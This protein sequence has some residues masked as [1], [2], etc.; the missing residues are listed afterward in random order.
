LILTVQILKGF[1]FQNI[2]SSNFLYQF[3]DT[4]KILEVT[5]HIY[6]IGFSFQIIGAINILV[7]LLISSLSSNVAKTWNLYVIFCSAV[8][9]FFT[10][11]IFILIVT[12]VVFV[13]KVVYHG[14]LDDKLKDVLF[15]EIGFKSTSLH[16]SLCSI[17]F[18]LIVDGLSF[19]ALSF[20]SST[21][22]HTKVDSSKFNITTN[23]LDVSPCVS[24][25]EFSN[26]RMSTL[27]AVPP[28]PPPPR[29]SIHKKKFSSK[30]CFDC[31][32]FVD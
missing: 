8:C 12:I 28:P 11:G 29:T 7:I 32:S 27:P 25:K 15:Y 23:S 13:S 31:L 26:T 6:F 9:T 14:N 22:D 24:K 2:T 18:S 4:K 1:G 20:S 19:F 3:N 16:A 10:L 17:F 30:R 21:S 5:I